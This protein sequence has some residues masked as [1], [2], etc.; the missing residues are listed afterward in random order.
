MSEREV[1]A[2][3]KGA[4]VM[5]GVIGPEIWRRAVLRALPIGFVVGVVVGA[6]IARYFG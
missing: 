4:E 6:V 2:F 3:R 1:A 5:R